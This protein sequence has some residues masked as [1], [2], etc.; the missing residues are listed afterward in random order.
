MLMMMMSQVSSQQEDAA[1]KIALIASEKERLKEIAIN[2]M[3]APE[4][5][6]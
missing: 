1:V 3:P 4:Q 6:V 2:E 5:C